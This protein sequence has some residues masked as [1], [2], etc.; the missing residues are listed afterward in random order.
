M[1]SPAFA[2]K[3]SPQ[4]V[5]ARNII[6]TLL[7]TLETAA[8]YSR[9]VQAT[10][11][12][13]GSKDQYGDNFFATALSDADPS[14]Q[15]LVE[16]TLLANFESLRFF[17]EEYE[18]SLNTKYFVD[19]DFGQSD[20][21]LIMLDPIDGTRCYL[22]KRDDYQIILSIATPATFQAVVVVLPAKQE[23]YYG[24]LGGKLVQGKFGEP[25]D[26]ARPIELLAS[27][28]RRVAGGLKTAP[29]LSPL[30]GK[31][32]LIL[33][34]DYSPSASSLSSLAMLTGQIDAYV[35][36][37]ANL[38]DGFAIS[39]MATLQGYSNS[40]LNGKP[41][42]TPGEHSNMIIDTPYITAKNDQIRQ[43][44]LEAMKN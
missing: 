23:Y 24:E 11:Q 32:E 29:L 36:M 8:R 28:T 1:T 42:T 40:D 44:I 13:F 16:T 14:V 27:E 34:D 5:Q 20:E 37:Y 10:I 7:P 12:D 21:L 43:T 38:I 30:K 18:Q 39:F 6:N 25:L 3:P 4:L 17:G 35:S 22:D 26:K 41:L 2:S 15:T 33:W 19:K 31:Y 9:K